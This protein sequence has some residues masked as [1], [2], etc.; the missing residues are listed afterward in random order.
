MY[1]KECPGHLSAR[2][3]RR[4]QRP[5]GTWS[6]VTLARFGRDNLAVG[7]F[8][9]DALFTGQVPDTNLT[10]R[11]TLRRAVEVRKV[12]L[13]MASAKDVAKVSQLTVRFCERHAA[14]PPY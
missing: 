7:H 12:H 6:V 2:L 13:G 8:S 10:A 11:Y 3:G 9:D 5:K 14:Q 4:L 1:E